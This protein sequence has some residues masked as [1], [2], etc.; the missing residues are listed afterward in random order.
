MYKKV[1]NYF[2]IF[3]F[4][5][6]NTIYAEN[7]QL[8]VPIGDYLRIEETLRS[9][10]APQTLTEKRFKEAM[11]AGFSDIRN[12][13]I[14]ERTGRYVFQKELKSKKD[15]W[16]TYYYENSLP[17]ELDGSVDDLLALYDEASKED[18]NDIETRYLI[19][20]RLARHRESISRIKPNL[21]WLLKKEKS[22]RVLDEI[23][24]AI[25][26]LSGKTIDGGKRLKTAY[27]FYELSPFVARG[28]VKDVAKELP[29][30]FHNKRGHE[31][32]VFIPYWDEIID[33]AVKKN[34]G[35]VKIEEVDG[36]S[37]ELEGEKVQLYSIVMLNRLTGKYEPID[38]VPI[39]LIKCDRYFSNIDKGDIYRQELDRTSHL[40]HPENIMTAVFFSKAVLEAMKVMKL[41]PDIISTADWQTAHVATLLKKSRNPEAYR[42]FKDTKTLHTIHN[43]GPKGLIMASPYADS[44]SDAKKMWDFMSITDDAYQPADQNGIEFYDMA[45]LQKGGIA[46]TD[47]VSTVSVNYASELKTQAFGSGFEGINAAANVIG[48]PNGIALR[49][50]NSATS[51]SIG[52]R[53]TNNPSEKDRR[54]GVLDTREGKRENKKSMTVMING[55]RR[56]KTDLPK[57]TCDEDTPV[58]CFLGRFDDQKGLK[59]LLDIL[60]YDN[61]M[62]G[63]LAGSRMKIVFAGTGNIHYMGK[64]KELEKTYP[65]SVAY[66]GWVDETTAKRLFA[67]ADINI[68]PSLFEP[69]GIV[70]MQA[71]R[72]GVVNLVN[73][74][75]GLKDDIIDFSEGENGNGYTVDF[76]QGDAYILLRDAMF[77]A[78]EDFD[79]EDKVGWDTKVRKVL[80][81]SEKYGWDLSCLKYE[82][83][84]NFLTGNTGDLL[85]KHR[86]DHADLASKPFGQIFEE[87][88]IDL[89][90][91]KTAA[92]LINIGREV[93]NAVIRNQDLGRPLNILLT[94]PTGFLKTTL[95]ETLKEILSEYGLSVEIV[96]TDFIGREENYFS[97]LN[98]KYG[99]RDVIIAESVIYFPQDANKAD[100]FIR[101]TGSLHTR[102]DRITQ[103]SGSYEYAKIRTEAE[104]VDFKERKED[105]SMDTD[106]INISHIE[107]GSFR[108]FL[109]KGVSIALKRNILPQSSRNAGQ[110]L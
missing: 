30:T 107:S 7:L 47:K 55:V 52:H 102:Q 73:K 75:G 17:V 95:A 27:V 15:A 67:G 10:Q 25:N 61:K 13:Y 20:K 3:A 68:M 44:N 109:E 65:D 5:F 56:Q 85:I 16:V 104:A 87:L 63:L 71:A 91:I 18:E 33:E 86:V 80:A 39:Y 24:V 6:C 4:L 50:W 98:K 19:F 94:G 69:K 11:G 32:S 45:S 110:S 46:Y 76:A 41:K 53:F 29:R 64:V 31:A 23:R 103:G 99:D 2:L 49:E 72:F 92:D 1:I 8:R 57:F 90:T 14:D 40:T 78:I 51:S 81:D 70:Q 58:F 96:Q 106:F 22:A 35:G 21:E 42:F 59:I 82:L 100:L 54:L 43:I 105:A 26:M 74:V 77:R 12:F 89:S 84:F 101:L 48:I 36:G 88:D 93:S 28:G 97:G 83:L 38:G 9:E 37:F 60:E 66:L 108:Y 34:N 62:K 79:G